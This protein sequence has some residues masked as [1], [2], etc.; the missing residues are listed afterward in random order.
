MKVADE[1]QPHDVVELL[2]RVMSEGADAPICA[3]QM[4]VADLV[5]LSEEAVRM[6]D[7][8]VAQLRSAKAW[9]D[10]TPEFRYAA[11]VCADGS[12]VVAGQTISAAF[13]FTVAQGEWGWC[14]PVA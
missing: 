4:T 9:R 7:A 14:R 1:R 8:E 2:R 11:Y 3:H 6:L 13:V 12:L 5:W 10:T